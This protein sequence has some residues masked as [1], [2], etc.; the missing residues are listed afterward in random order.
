MASDWF[1]GFRVV[2]WFRSGLGVVSEWYWIGLGVI[3]EWFWSGFGLFLE[4]GFGAW[5]S[6][7]VV[8]CAVSIF[9]QTKKL[10][11]QTFS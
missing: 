10:L 11:C 1:C 7:L 2:L 8:N 3:L 6:G 4:P 9:I 5:F